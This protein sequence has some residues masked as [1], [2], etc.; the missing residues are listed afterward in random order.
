M[1]DK[2]LTCLLVLIVLLFFSC[3]SQQ[4]RNLNDEDSCQVLCISSTK[5]SIQDSISALPKGTLERMRAIVKSISK[6]SIVYLSKHSWVGKLTKQYEYAN[7]L[8]SI[9]SSWQMK[10]IALKHPSAVVRAA[11]FN[12]LLR[13]DSGAAVDVAIS[14]INDTTMVQILSADIEGYEHLNVLRINALLINKDFYKVSDRD[15]DRLDSVVLFSKSVKRFDAYGHLYSDMMPK[16]Q[17]YKRLKS[18]YNDETYTSPIVAI[19]KYNNE[20]SKDMLTD[21][22][23]L[24]GTR[25]SMNLCNALE[26]ISKCPDIRYKP[27]VQKIANSFLRQK[28]DFPVEL[29]SALMS[30]EEQW[31]VTL[32]DS[33][34][35]DNNP[36]WN[37][38]YA[39]KKHPRTYF[40]AIYDKYCS[41]YNR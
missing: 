15:Y 11:V 27:Y 25:H 24:E 5:E 7:H 41:R 30:Y 4:E 20:E 23:D 17:Y 22:L 21:L 18:L 38:Y 32:I 1:S 6:D 37:F 8:S 40:K 10:R 9:A 36:E 19:V 35:A 28:V 14:G 12:A 39:Y 33:S 2:Q 3:S 31:T 16:P 34:M 29:Y 26:A 13:K